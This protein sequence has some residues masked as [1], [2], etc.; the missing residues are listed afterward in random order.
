V[1]IVLVLASITALTLDARGSSVVARFRSNVVESL[2]PVTS[3]TNGFFHPVENAWNGIFHYGSLKKDNDALRAQ[4]AQLQGSSAVV[5]AK[6]AQ[7]KEYYALLNLP[8]VGDI[9]WVTAN[10]VGARPSNF[11]QTIQLDRGSAD[12]VKVGFPVV[13]GAGLVGRVIRVSRHASA[14][15]VVTDTAFTA[16]VVVGDDATAL[17]RGE[18]VG[19]AM[20]VELVEKPV[21]GNL[22]ADAPVNPVKV[23][24]AVLTSGQDISLYPRDIPVGHV[25]SV[26]SPPGSGHLLISLKPAVDLDH[27]SLVKILKWDPPQVRP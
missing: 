9:P 20:S 14:V 22:S 26:L 6:E 2:R 12:G 1:L 19:K 17:A 16:G 8:W 13:T 11:D 21:V 24:M 25:A 23:G 4:L 5:N 27:L 7:M 15:R 3:S 18:G 10:L